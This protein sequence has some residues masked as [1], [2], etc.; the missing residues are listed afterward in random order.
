MVDSNDKQKSKR[1]TNNNE[2]LEQPPAQIFTHHA[3]TQ[4]G[5]KGTVRRRRL[6]KTHHLTPQIASTSQEMH[7]FVNKFKLSNYGTIDSVTFIKDT[8]KIETF[9]SVDL[10]ANL[11]NGIFQLNINNKNKIFNK[12]NQLIA[13]A[14]VVDSA[15]NLLN[16]LN[17]EQTSE[18]R[19]KEIYELIGSDADE[20]LKIINNNNNSNNNK[21]TVLIKSSQILD[22]NYRSVGNL[23][24]E[25]LFENSRKQ[26]K[27]GDEVIGYSIDYD[28]N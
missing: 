21:S 22:S 28:G 24:Q 26:T 19:I 6:R 20:Y 10:F 12:H 13:K 17:Y 23:N 14:S 25:I 8:G 15:V 16:E 27:S 11:N 2:S 9:N 7:N 18:E 3:T 4:I 1:K 5:G